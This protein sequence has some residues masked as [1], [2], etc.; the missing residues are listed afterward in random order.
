[1]LTPEEPEPDIELELEPEPDP[2]PAPE[3]ELIIPIDAEVPP[4]PPDGG[5]PDDGL[6]TDGDAGA[7]A[8][9]D[10][11]NA[12][13]TDG[14]VPLFVIGGA[15]I[16]LFAPVGVAAWSL[17]NLI[18]SIVGIVF[19]GVAG[20]RAFLKGRERERKAS[21]S[22]QRVVE[23]PAVSIEQAI[24]NAEDKASGH[25]GEKDMLRPVH[26]IATFVA[27]IIGIFLFVL[28]QDMRT[29]MVL[30]DWWTI[31]HAILV[32]IGILGTLF[33]FK[34]AK[35]LVRFN[36]NG[37]GNPFDLKVRHG[38]KIKP[39]RVPMRQGYAFAGWYSDDK[40]NAKYDFNERIDKGMTLY[41]K[42]IRSPSRQ[43]RPQ[44]GR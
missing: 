33:L 38:N 28:I 24:T 35:E 2:G 14:S 23:A 43:A 19:A 21:E 30:V 20:V 1:L 15:E 16:P 37:A 25:D 9:T 27:A 13:I 34:V 36:T 5:L 11:E 10:V 40:F 22:R 31:A 26:L 17:V 29:P 18:L 32:V 4:P 44:P 6:G 8:R 42:W 12:W 3:P 41:A 39:P 7:G